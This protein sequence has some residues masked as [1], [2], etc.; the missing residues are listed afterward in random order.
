ML[1]SSVPNTDSFDTEGQIR[2]SNATLSL[3]TSKGH[4]KQNFDLAHLASFCLESHFGQNFLTFLEPF[5]EYILGRLG[6]AIV[7]LLKHVK[8]EIPLDR[9]FWNI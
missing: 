2:S 5:S 3:W 9:H 4:Y 6:V 1:K 8:S 7:D